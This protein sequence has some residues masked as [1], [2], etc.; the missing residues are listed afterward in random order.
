MRQEIKLQPEGNP[1]SIVATDNQ[2]VEAIQ[3]LRIRLNVPKPP[4]VI[5]PRLVVRSIGI[6]QFKGG[7]IPAIPFAALDARKLAG[8]LVAPADKKHFP[9]DRIDARVLDGSGAASGE[10]FGVF[11][12]LSAQIKERKLRAG[13][14]VFLVIESHVLNLEP[15]GTL[16]LGSD[17]EIN[18]MT[19]DTS[20]PTQ[21]ISERLE[22]VASEGCLVVLLLDG[23]HGGMPA[24]PRKPVLTEWVRDLNKRGVIVLLASKQDPSERLTQS[25]AFAQAILDSVTVA[26][27]AARPGNPD[28]ATSPTL[29]DFQATVINRVREL[30]GRRQFA[31]FFPP[32]FLNWQDIRIF[33]PQPTPASFQAR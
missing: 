25:G 31:D 3:N 2:G 28:R 20:V 16:V 29:D 27:R 4:K 9:D 5:G 30:T 8:F 17:A 33:E 12:R 18:K 10:I 7:N 13:D 26:G 14:T 1:I 32:E 11:E 19:A 21:A 23:I 15:R 24:P 22:E 6:E